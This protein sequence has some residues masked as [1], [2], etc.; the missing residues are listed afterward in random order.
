VIRYEEAHRLCGICFNLQHISTTSFH[1]ACDVI[2]GH[3]DDIL[4]QLNSRKDIQEFTFGKT[5]TRSKNYFYFPIHNTDSWNLSGIR[6]AWKRYKN[7]GF[8]NLIVVSVIDEHQIPLFNV[9]WPSNE[10]EDFTVALKQNLIHRYRITKKD[11]RLGNQNFREGARK[12]NSHHGVL[13]LAIKYKE[14]V[15]EDSQGWFYLFCLGIAFLIWPQ[16]MGFALLYFIYVL[17]T[18]GQNSS[19]NMKSPSN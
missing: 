6:S 2:Q 12:T 1:T 15:Q 5:H 7:L 10:T 14:P 19:K 16:I 18:R 3:V 13:Y 11:P 8:H 9:L 17:Y 4:Q